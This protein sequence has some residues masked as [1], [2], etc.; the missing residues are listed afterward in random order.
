V[1]RGPRQVFCVGLAKCGTHSVV[2][3]LEPVCRAAHE[4][5]SEEL[6]PLLERARAGSFEVGELRSFLRERD[7][8]LRL[9]FEANHLLGSFVPHLMDAFPEA[10]FILLVRELRPWIDSLINDQLNLR[11]WDGYTRWRVVYDQY[12]GREKRS[13]PPEEAPLQDLDLY[14][15]SHYIRYWREEPRAI[16]AELPL[17]RVLVLRTEALS[18]SLSTI[19]EFVG[20][21]ETSLASKAS[22]TYLTA[23]KHNVLDSLDPTYL[24][25][26]F[27]RQTSVTTRA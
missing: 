25:G 3:M 13:F 1:K 9:D 12:L 16:L 7:R 23:R 8:R 2:D 14:P 4:P 5:G 19:A 27:A 26:V 15:L 22:H 24:D 17:D 10:R 21:P 11:Q 6:L 20:V 18:D